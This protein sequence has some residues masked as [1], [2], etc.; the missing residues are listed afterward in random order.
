MRICR[1]LLA[2]PMLVIHVFTADVRGQGL[3]ATL[4]ASVILVN[5]IAKLAIT[6]DPVGVAANTWAAGAIQGAQRSTPSHTCPW[7]QPVQIGSRH[8]SL[9]NTT[10]EGS[11]ASAS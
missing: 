8:A 11:P 7:Y 2:W 9:H 6:M 5:P 1:I 3:L 4:C 10:Y